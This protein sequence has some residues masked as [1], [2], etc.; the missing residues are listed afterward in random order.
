MLT[1]IKTKT[2]LVLFLTLILSFAFF[3]CAEGELTQEE[4][5][6]I[7]ADAATTNAE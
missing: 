1:T 5:E 7:V 4:I 6:Q 3:G 2:I